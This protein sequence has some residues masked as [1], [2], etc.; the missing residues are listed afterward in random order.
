LPL[1][2]RF[3]GS[4]KADD[5]FLGVIKISTTP[6]LLGEVKPLAAY[7]RFCSML[8]TSLKYERDNS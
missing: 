2:P 3:T 4:N 6:S 5:R 1:D 7:L 8:K